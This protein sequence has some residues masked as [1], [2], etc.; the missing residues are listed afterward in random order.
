MLYCKFSL[1]QTLWKELPTEP[2]RGKQDD[3]FF[4]DKNTG[5]YGN[6]KGKIYQT[7]NG[8]ESWELK[9]EMTGTF[10]R[11]LHFLD[12]LHGF[13]GNVGTDYFPGVTD[14]IALYETFDGGT[15]WK[16]A[17]NILGEYPKGLCAFFEYKKLFIN[18]GNPDYK[19]IL[20]A[21]GRV[22]G[23]AFFMKST[24]EGKTWQSQKLSIPCAAIMDVCFT[25]LDTGFICSAS[26]GDIEKSAASIFKTT[27]GGK[28]WRNVYTGKR[29]FETTWK[30]SFPENKTGYATLQSYN[31]DT[32][33]TRRYLL[34]T[35]NNGES[36][37]EIPFINNYK[38][39]EF[40]IAFTDKSHGF[41]GTTVGGFETTD[42]GNTWTANEFGNY[43]NKIRVVSELNQK[44]LFAI[45]NK[46]FKALYRK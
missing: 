2:Y 28:T 15:T 26:D 10:V 46:I 12:T 1:C 9:S 25:S 45:G 35:E 6:G 44:Y 32:T 41:V 8:G 16:P 27:D 11:C 40:G 30:F 20:F 33:V 24:D 22:G 29:F 5:W 13:M 21:A 36:W 37:T 18:S 34:K 42:G 4:I 3:I 7:R 17:K 14:T 31:P 43:V 19:K 38:L 23:P 39:R